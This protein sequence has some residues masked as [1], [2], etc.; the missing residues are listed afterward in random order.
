MC[1]QP[2]NSMPDL[3]FLTL[4]IKDYFFVGNLYENS[5]RGRI[6]GF[7]L[8]GTVSVS[9]NNRKVIILPHET[10]VAISPWLKRRI[11]PSE[12]RGWFSDLTKQ[13][14]LFIKC[15]DKKYWREREQHY[16]IWYNQ[17]TEQTDKNWISKYLLFPEMS[18]HAF[19][20]IVFRSTCHSK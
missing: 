9:K 13:A 5:A 11:K 12:K 8:R 2:S 10:P 4:R 17:V 19:V 14:M 20:L 18:S 15:V 6:K 1:T 3:I 16:T 7:H